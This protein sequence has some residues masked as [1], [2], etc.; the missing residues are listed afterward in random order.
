M[1]DSMTTAA[2]A[3]VAPPSSPQSSAPAPTQGYPSQPQ[4]QSAPTSYQTSQAPQHFSPDMVSTAA[5]QTPQPQANPWQQ[6]YE[7]L[8]A[9]LNATRQSQPQ[10]PSS[11]PIP[12][13]AFTQ[14]PSPWGTQ[15]PQQ[16][17]APSAQWQTPSA[18]PSVAQPAMAPMTQ[19]APSSNAATAP[20]SDGY[21]ESVSDESL[22]V[23]QHFGAEAPAILNRY[24]C[25]MEDALIAQCR[26]TVD[27]MDQMQT[28]AEGVGQLEMLLNAAV[29]DNKAA[30]TLLTDPDHLANYVNDF[31]GPEGPYPVETSR[32]RLAADLAANGYLPQEQEAQYQEYQGE[33]E[34]SEY[35]EEGEEVEQA[36]AM[37]YRRPTIDMPDP[38]VQATRMGD[39]RQFWENFHV[40]ARQRPELTY[41]M[42]DQ[43]PPEFYRTRT[44]ISDES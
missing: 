11:L 35:E 44:F 18:Y 24:S 3:P 36:A 9:S 23:L 28:M 1:Q 7:S 16:V 26:Q 33:P 20:S 6:A 29:E 21:L 30:N 4:A 10:A 14:A 31:F 42:L 15:A 38:G 13:V 12:P 2:P 27:A 22:S 17:Q 41:Q 5:P 39:A 34:Y 40:I 8:T 43:A 32:D 19:A 37:Q 25:A